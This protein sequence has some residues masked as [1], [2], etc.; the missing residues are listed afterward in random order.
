MFDTSQRSSV[1]YIFLKRTSCE[2]RIQIFLKTLTGKTISLN[3]VARDTTDSV[4]AKIQ[5]KTGVPQDRQ[6]LMFAGKQLGSGRC[7]LDYNIQKECMLQ[8]VVRLLGGQFLDL[9]SV[10]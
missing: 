9:R 5:D 4:K 1:C 2:E 3:V 6:R 10:I 7:L 8:L